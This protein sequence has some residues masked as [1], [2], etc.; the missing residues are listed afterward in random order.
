MSLTF[1]RQRSW[2]AAVQPLESRRLLAAAAPTELAQY[3]VELI[4]RARANPAAEAARLGIDLNEGIAPGTISAAPKQPLAI[5]P[6]ITDAARGHS[7]WM[8]QTDIFDHVGE[9]GTSPMRRMQ[10]AGYSFVPPWA[11]GENIAWRGIWPTIP[12]PVSTTAQLHEDL[13]VDEGYPQRGHRTNLLAPYF[14]EMGAGIAL[15]E[16]EGYN[17]VV[18]TT[19]FAFTGSASF[20]TGV[21][22]TDAVTDDDFY[23][24]GEGLGDILVT[25]RRTS[26]SA[27]FTTTTWDSGGYSLRLPAGTYDVIAAGAGLGADVRLS[28]V[29]IGA[30]NVQRDFVPGATPSTSVSNRWVFYNNSSYDGRNPAATVSD[31]L[32]LASDKQA[33]LPG[34]TASFANVT[35]YSKGINGVLV[36]FAGMPPATLRASDFGFRV[37]RG[38]SPSGWAAA[39]APASVVNLPSPGGSNTARYHLG[40][41]RD[42]QPVAPGHREGERRHRPGGAGR[43]LLRQPRRRDRRRHHGHKPACQRPRPGGRETV[44]QR[45]GPRHRADRFRPRRARQ[46]ARLGGGAGEPFEDAGSHRAADRLKMGLMDKRH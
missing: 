27:L 14:K 33:L 41:R 35:S 9:G 15:G 37:G 29:V 2:T 4:N 22:Y 24:P 1:P 34:H 19:D 20:L 31:L 36:D 12:E 30:E 38:A 45:D 42:R 6:F 26:D 8:E 11:S 28:N 43:V 7:Q 44:A 25:A 23:T 13:F 39:P 32:A 5:N 21:A 10:N 46:R 16:I 17:A 40:R 18:V 3:M